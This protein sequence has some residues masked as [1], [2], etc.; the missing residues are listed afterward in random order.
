VGPLTADMVRSL[1]A[2]KS[3]TGPIVSLYL[4]VDGQRHIRARDYEHELDRMLREVRERGGGAEAAEAD[5]RRVEAFVKAGIDRSR[6]RGIAVFASSADAL[7][8]TVEL[9]VGVRNHLAVDHIVH[10]RQLEGLLE[11]Y[12]RYGVLL[13]DRQRARLMVFRA[14]E[15]HDRSELFDELPRHDDDGGGWDRDHVRDHAEAQAQHHLRR[16]AQAAFSLH[17]ERPFDH[18]VLSGPEAAVNDV[19]RELLRRISGGDR[20]AFRD[21]YLRYHRRLARFLTRL[22]HAREDAEEIINDTLWIVWQ[23]AGDFRNASRVSTWIMGIAYRRA[24]KLF[25]RAATHARAMTL[26]IAEGEPTASDALEA[27]F[28]RRLL[29]R[30][31]AQLPLEQRLVL[32][33]TYYLD[34]SCEEIADIM[35]CPVNT[36]KTRMF[37]AKKK[38]QEVLEQRGLSGEMP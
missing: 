19:E 4:D 23:R 31:L 3:T 18:L 11:R 33:F 2:R 17:Q 16:A 12:R 9:A 10:I 5:L 25:R 30:G 8:E 20:D 13:I 29:E 22:T 32:E 6:T 28:D 21:L 24:L 36:V 37:Y 35:E 27:A 26:E 38:L 15:V 7:F 1:A 14:G 34:H